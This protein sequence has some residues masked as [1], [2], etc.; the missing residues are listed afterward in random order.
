MARGLVFG[1][2]LIFAAISHGAEGFEEVSF[3]TSDGGSVKR[4]SSS[5]GKV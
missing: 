3:E 1:V 2:F 5:A 4:A